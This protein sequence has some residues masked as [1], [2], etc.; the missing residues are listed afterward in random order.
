[1]MMS[2]TKS[3]T[4]KQLPAASLTKSVA[5]GGNLSTTS[6]IL[7]AF[8]SGA[9]I[10]VFFLPAWRIDLFA[11]QY[12][13]GLKMNIWIN[14]LSGEV[15][16]INGLNH[17]IGMKKISAE[18][19]P[20]FKFL[21]YVVGFYMLL[22]ILS[23]ITGKRKLLSLYLILTVIGGSLAM[24]DFYQWG[25]DYGHNLDPSAP[26][27]VKDLSYQ[28]PL[29][30]HKRLLNF[31]AY[32]YPDAGGWIV[33]ISSVLVFGVWLLEWYKARRI[34]KLTTSAITVATA[35]LVLSS[36]SAKPDPFSYGKDNCYTCKMG[37]IDTRYGAETITKKG[38]VY[39]F[40]DIVCM[41]RFL[42]SGALAEKTIQQNVVINFEKKDDF[43]DVKNASFLISTQLKTPMS[44]NLA[45][46]SNNEA[47]QKFKVKPEDEI[48]NWKELYTRIQ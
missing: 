46:F 41:V 48:V 21:P 32:S 36:C 18:M 40:D 19:F 39:K 3:K 4:E 27:Q 43:I 8:A 5:T 12:P 34:K 6:R 35:A 28:P 10:A 20:E 13:E 26:I 16:V 23:A 30:G 45:A 9:L 44:S 33:I 47:I 14:G 22:G 7:V 11:P 24:Y 29:F 1:M 17:Y 42:K 2:T 37:I 38:K 15:D 25:Y 31:D